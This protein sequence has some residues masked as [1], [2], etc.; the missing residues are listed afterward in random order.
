MYEF[1]SSLLKERNMWRPFKLD[2]SEANIKQIKA[3]PE[4]ALRDIAGLEK[5]QENTIT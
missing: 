4:T 1:I 2:Q 3:N 5:I